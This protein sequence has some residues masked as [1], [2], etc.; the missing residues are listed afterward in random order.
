MF[1]RADQIV[2]AATPGPWRAYPSDPSDPA[3]VESM[4][5]AVEVVHGA[6]SSRNAEFVA[7]FDPVTVA[8]LLDVARAAQDVYLHRTREAYERL[9]SCLLRLREV[10]PHE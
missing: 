8:A 4:S 3:Y 7:T 6:S 2:K 1:D 5:V 9:V 10:M